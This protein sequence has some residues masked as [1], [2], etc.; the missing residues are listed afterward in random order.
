MFVL[1]P[2]AATIELQVLQAP[3]ITWVLGIVS[4]YLITTLIVRKSVYTPLD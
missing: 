3:H 1:T 4:A 2:F